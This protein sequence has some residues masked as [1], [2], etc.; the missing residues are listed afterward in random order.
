[1][2]KH[3]KGKGIVLPIKYREKGIKPKA[4]KPTFASDGYRSFNN[5][6]TDAISLHS[7]TVSTSTPYV[8]LKEWQKQGSKWAPIHRKKVSK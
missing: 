8:T 2:I 6:G 7:I 4:H 5:D 3:Y 1:M